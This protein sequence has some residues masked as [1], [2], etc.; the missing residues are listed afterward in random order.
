MGTITRIEYQAIHR[1]LR[2]DYGSAY[3]CENTCCLKISSYFNWSLDVGCKYEKNRDNFSQLCR[4][5]HS[6]QDNKNTWDNGY[7]SK[8]KGRTQVR[9]TREHVELALAWVHGE[10]RYSQIMSV[11]DKE[12][13]AL[14]TI[15]AR[16]LKEYIN[17]E[18]V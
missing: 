15:L 6:I 10:V 18:K 9:I 1:W 5:C 11:L 17:H 14:Y 7:K 8:S 13:S 4:Q 2:K 3:R 12:G 16:S